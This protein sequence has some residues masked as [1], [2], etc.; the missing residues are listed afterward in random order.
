MFKAMALLCKRADMSKE[1]FI[2]YYE[3]VGAKLLLKYQPQLC[4]F[5]RNFLDLNGAVIYPGAKALDFDVIAEFW[6]PDRA[7]Y[8]AAMDVFNHKETDDLLSDDEDKFL[9]R[10]K[11]RFFIVDEFVSR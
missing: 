6:Y 5:R 4:G 1:E 3:K 2:E 7:A 11:T 10:T 9:D 8:E